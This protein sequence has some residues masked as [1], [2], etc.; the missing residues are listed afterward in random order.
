MFLPFLAQYATGGKEASA[1]QAARESL[2]LNAIY[3]DGIAAAMGKLP[4]S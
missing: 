3:R 1:I 4:A 2:E